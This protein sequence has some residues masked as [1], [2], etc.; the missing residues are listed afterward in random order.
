MAIIVNKGT[1]QVV[2]GPPAVLMINKATLQ[3]VSGPAY[4]GVYARKAT[5][6]VVSGPG[7]GKRRIN[8]TFI[9]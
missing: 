7:P 2:S 8:L 9:P 1:M 4:V 5:L 3:V 6:Q